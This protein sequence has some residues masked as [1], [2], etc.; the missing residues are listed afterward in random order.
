MPFFK[1]IYNETG[2]DQTAA[3]YR[4]VT[5]FSQGM[6]WEKV[7]PFVEDAED[8]YIRPVLGDTFYQELVD[9]IAADSLTAAQIAALAVL[10]PAVAWFTF[11]KTILGL[12][13]SVSELGPAEAVDS[14]GRWLF[15]RQWVSE[16][17][18]L[19]AFRNGYRKLEDALRY[20]ENNEA[21][22]SSWTSST[23]YTK[24]VEL[25]IPNATVLA[26]Y[27]PLDAGRSVFVRLKPAIR[28]AELRY[29][30]PVLGTA[31][32]DALKTLLRTPET[33]PS[34]AQAEL[35]DHIRRALAEWM[36]TYAVPFFRLTWNEIGIIEPAL[37]TERSK[38]QAASQEAIA[39]LWQSIQEAGKGFLQT[40]KTFLDIN[41]AS[42]PE[43]AD[44]K[45]PTAPLG[46]VDENGRIR[47]VVQ[48]LD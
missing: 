36:T 31:L 9:A 15:P 26:E 29:I 18:R 47:N 32:Y 39:G 20:L 14:D 21:D 24:E 22:Y 27:M 2:D 46:Q 25:F 8:H 43:Y 45:T 41:A 37:E 30:K 1:Y 19:R 13:M 5:A 16:A 28:K 34:V 35:L 3:L 33:A 48:F 40:L 38:Q 17:G 7:L 12:A 23:A 11:E 44:T 10:R 42:F 6:A 4:Y